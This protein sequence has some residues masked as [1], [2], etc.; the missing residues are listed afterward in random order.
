MNTVQYLQQLKGNPVYQEE[1]DRLKSVLCEA[2]ILELSATPKQKIY[3]YPF[4]IPTSN[5]LLVVKPDPNKARTPWDYKLVR[6]DGTTL[7]ED[8]GKMYTW[9]HNPYLL[10]AGIA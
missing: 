5:N 6:W 10:W 7:T 9:E 8:C 1:Y 2:D 4:C 3:W